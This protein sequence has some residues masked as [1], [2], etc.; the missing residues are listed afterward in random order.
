[1]RRQG[2]RWL[3]HAAAAPPK[4]RPGRCLHKRGHRR[5]LMAVDAT[6]DDDGAVAAAPG[7]A[8]PATP[9]IA[10]VV[11]AHAA[12]VGRVLRCLGVPDPDVAD[13]TQR[14]FLV[15]HRRLGEFEGR[16]KL[17]T[18]LYGICVRVAL[19]ERRTARRRRETP[20]AEPAAHEVCARTPEQALERVRALELALELLAGL[21]DDKRAVF[22]LYEVEQLPM[23]EV[24]RVLGC[25]VQT[26]YTRLHAARAELART[27]KRLRAQG[28]AE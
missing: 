16:A 5:A 21:D 10:D 6:L 9:A 8:A 27:L 2:G 15:A 22:V 18:W 28:R 1:M 14:V 11:T 17:T 25:P 7:A 3:G 12:W 23:P 13:A 24:A 26:A 20:V 4:W 19:S